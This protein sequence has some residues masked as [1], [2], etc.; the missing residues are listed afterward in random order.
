LRNLGNYEIIDK[1]GEGGMGEV[2]RAR[3]R[4]LQRMV[5]LKV[6]PQEVAGDPARRAR[7]EQE[8]RALGALNHPNIV[9]I[10][11][12]GE[13]TGRAYIVSELVEGESLRAVLDRGPLPVRK[14]VEIAGQMADGMAAAHALGI[15]HRDLKPENVMV[16]RAG[17]VKLLDFGL[18]KQNAPATGDNTATIAMALSQPGMVMG[19]VGY[20]SPEQVRGEPADA[21]SDIFSFG[22]VLYEMLAGRRAFEARTGVETMHAIL[23]LD[24]PEFAGE[25]AKL[26][27]AVTTIVRRCLEKRPE[28]RFQSAADLAFALRSIPGVSVTGMQPVAAP[29]APR[30]SWVWPV[31]AVASGLALFALG[32]AVRNRTLNRERPHFR[33]ITFRKGFVLSA[34][35]TPGGHDAVYQAAWEGSASHIY[36]AVP[37]SPESRDLEMPPDAYLASLS[38]QQELALLTSS[39]GAGRLVRTSISGGQTRPLLDDVLAADWA[40]DGSSLAVLRQ[41]NGLNRLEYPIGTVLV[42]NI[43]W[44][45]HMIRV[46]PDGGRVAFVSMVEG[47]AVGMSVVDRSGKRTSLGAVSGQNST[48]EVSALCWSPK[49]DEIWFHSFDPSEPGIVYAIDLKGRRRVALNLPSQMKFYDIARTGDALLTTGSVQFGILGAAPGETVERDLSCLNSGRV[50]GISDD[51]RV[52]AADILGEGGGPKGSIYE[53][54]TD[55]SRAIRVSDGHVYKLSPDGNWVSGYMLNS[56]GSRRFVLL[57][58]GPGEETMIDPPGLGM[59]VGYAWLDGEQRYLVGGSLRG[60]KW[61]CFVW[62]AP[63]KTLQPVC[64]EGAPDS[65]AYYVSPDRKQVLTVSP[66][67][68]WIAYP[69]DGGPAQEVHGIGPHEAVIGW[70][71]DSRSLYV[72]P[73]GESTTSIPVSIVEIAT[74]NRSAWKTI[75]PA[76]P[77]LEIHDLHVTPDGQ[78]YA[79]NYVTAQSD[80]YVAHGLN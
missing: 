35:F 19:T 63:R 34:R 79:Y 46:S 50:V 62:D 4:R 59:A 60:K 12:V 71:Q 28:Q 77:V 65:L 37:G 53:R 40:P 20:M 3:D 75:H 8:A 76:Q 61:Q 68:G 45:L 17:Q 29:R 7:F 2:W 41:V 25:Q 6:L 31:T 18:A 48:G 52:I 33:R 55:G 57:P 54:R 9:A 36:L 14:A 49:G 15:V 11:D 80:L 27:P 30:K 47:T 13:D 5:A 73:T 24:P 43:P 67:G 78:A 66:Q 72:R 26:P 42:D 16:T 32:F 38:S 69:V 70:R 23:N 22:C 56:D 58:T 51:G 10:Y 1:L 64:P 39:Q 21:R 74:G 44:P